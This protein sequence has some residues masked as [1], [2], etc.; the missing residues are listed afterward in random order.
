MSKIKFFTLIGTAF[1]CVLVAGCRYDMQDQPRLKYYKQSEFFANEMGSRPL[2]EG[3]VPRGFLRED[4]ALYQG[5]REGATTGANAGGNQGGQ[6]QQTGQNNQQQLASPPQQSSAGTTASQGTPTAATNPNYP[7]AVTEFPFPVT[8]ELI[9]RGEERYRVFCIVCHGPNGDGNGMI[10]R[11]G[12]EGVKSYHTDE[13][14]AAPVGHFYD[15]VANGWGRMNGYKDMIPVYDRWAIVA[16]IRTLQAAQNPDVL[17]QVN[18]QPQSKPAAGA[19]PDPSHGG[20][21]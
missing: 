21:H 16:Y 12:Y 6:Q 9:N 19:T 4:R 1:C 14:R 5:K 20:A 17:Q 11:R 18:S 10:A 2:V 3:T 13:L 7:D 15:V 8:Q